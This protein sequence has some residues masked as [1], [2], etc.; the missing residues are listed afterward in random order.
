MV[1]ILLTTLG[2]GTALIYYRRHVDRLRQAFERSQ[3]RDDAGVILDAIDG[4]R[5]QVDSHQ[6]HTAL[7]HKAIL[8]GQ[9]LIGGRAQWLVANEIAKG[10]SDAKARAEQARKEDEDAGSGDIDGSRT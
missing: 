2:I 6:M 10:L 1:A 8:D 7:E 9:K 3:E 5:D 4:M